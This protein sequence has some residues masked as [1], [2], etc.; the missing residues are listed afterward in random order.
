MT[1]ATRSATTPAV[2]LTQRDIEAVSW[3]AQQHAA[4]LDTVGRMLAGIGQPVEDRA[5]R[6][7]AE[8]WTAAGLVNRR[9]VLADAPSILWAT[10]DG[11]RCAGI[12]LRAGQRADAPSIGTLHHTLA[13]AEV[14]LAYEQQGYDWTAERFLHTVVTSDH[15]A[16]GLAANGNHRVLVEVERTQKE[17]ERLTDILRANLRAP[18]ITETHYWIT[19]KMRGIVE[20][21]AA[22][23]E[24]ELASRVRVALLPAV[25]R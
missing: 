2:R 14:R 10:A 3:I 15:R 9:R 7:L 23:L 21:A 22:E 17:R 8:R 4:R 1:T 5:L 13:V 16:D 25:V 24:P 6:R 12:T 18:G 20:A 11:L 19:E